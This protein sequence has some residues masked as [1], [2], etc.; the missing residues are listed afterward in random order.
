ME[1]I[2]EMPVYEPPRVLNHCGYV[3]YARRF[4]HKIYN[5]L[6]VEYTTGFIETRHDQRRLH[7]PCRLGSLVN[8]H[9]IIYGSIFETLRALKG[10]ELDGS[11]F[12]NSL[13][14]CEC[15][16]L[17]ALRID[18]SLNLR[19]TLTAVYLQSRSI[20]NKCNMTFNADVCI[21]LRA[22]LIQKLA[23]L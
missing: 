2:S 6:S 15:S 11:L 21:V 22:I 14:I 8:Y 9:D 10:I 19:G 5:I 4:Q 7:S 18:D 20:G 16:L 12:G 23:A 1:S 17:F 13:R 3:L